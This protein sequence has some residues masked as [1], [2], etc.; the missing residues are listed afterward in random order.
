MKRGELIILN[1]IFSSKMRL[2]QMKGDDLYALLSA[3]ADISALAKETEDKAETLR[4][5]VKP[6]TVD[7]FTA[8]QSDPDVQQWMRRYIPMQNRLYNEEQPGTLPE[9]CISRKDFPKMCE[10]LTPGEAELVMK[11][12]VKG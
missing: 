10:G 9:P 12:L 6:E 3:K 8:D 5:G 1:G 7:E 4:M 11:Y 2:P